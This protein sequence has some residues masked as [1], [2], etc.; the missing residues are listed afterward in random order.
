MTTWA[1][2]ATRRV[3]SPRCPPA[4]RIRVGFVPAVRLCAGVTTTYG[5]ATPPAGSFTAVSA[6]VW[7]SCG[8]R[9]SGSVVCW[10][11]QRGLGGRRHPTPPAGSFTAVRCPPAPGIRVRL[12]P[13]VRL[14]AGAD[15]E[16]WAGDATVGFVH[17]GVRRR[18]AFVCAWYRRFGCVLGP[19]RGWAGDA[20]RRFVHCG[21]RRFMAFVWGSYQTVRLCAGVTTRM[22]RRRHRRVRSPRC[23]PAT[24]IRVGFVPVVRLCAGA[25]TILGRRRHRRVRS[26]RCPP[27]PCIRVGFVPVVRLCAGAATGLGGRRHPSGSF[28]AVSAG[29]LHSCGVRTDGSVVCWGDGSG[30]ATP[31]PLECGASDATVGFVHRGVHRRLAFVWGSYRRFGCVL[32]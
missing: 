6:G 22:G 32:G 11:W 9:T 30:R 14:C 10:G 3:R 8:V 18:L 5:Q 23:P 17:R 7:H 24:C 15:N 12:V 25:A 4:T 16:Y 13:T 26:P 19:Q 27:A 29:H 21:V 2:D 28:T 20:T 1:G 31:R